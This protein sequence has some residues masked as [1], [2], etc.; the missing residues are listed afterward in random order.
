M[1][2]EGPA[3]ELAIELSENQKAA[4]L[5]EEGIDAQVAAE[6]AAP[7]EEPEDKKA[8][9]NIP[10]S[11]PVEIT[12][13]EDL[14]RALESH[15]VWLES[16]LNPSKKIGVGRA[17][18]KGADMSGWD[19]TGINLSGAT[20]KQAKLIGTKLTK[21]NLTATDFTNADLQGADLRNAKLKRAILT[22]ADLRDADLDGAD[23]TLARTDFTKFTPKKAEGAPSEDVEQLAVEENTDP[24]NGNGQ[25]WPAESSDDASLDG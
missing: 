15:Y 22:H 6:S 5:L 14:D 9:L 4:L 20:L 8:Y 13:R 2:T 17:N 23:L 10:V 19:L 16:V 11:M 1:N 24:A 21:A 7:E 18:L 25:L 3:N 12:C